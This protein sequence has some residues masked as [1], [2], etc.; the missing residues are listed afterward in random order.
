MYMMSWPDLACDSAARVTSSL[1]PV[2]VKRSICTSTFSFAAHSCTSASEAL[3]APGTQWS[4]KPIVSLP[5]ACAVR[6]RGAAIVAA[7]AAV[8][9]AMKRRR[10][11]GFLFIAFPPLPV[12]QLAQVCA[13]LRL[14]LLAL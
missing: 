8:V 11:N 9:A 10:V 2:L 12:R 5:A 14:L 1:L 7:A 3:L 6:T 13:A 4:H